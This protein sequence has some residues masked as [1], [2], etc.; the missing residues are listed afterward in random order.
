MK[1]KILSVL[2]IVAMVFGLCMPIYAATTM[3][4]T[5]ATYPTTLKQ[6]DPFVAKGVIT[7]DYYIRKVVIGVYNSSGAAEFDYTGLPGEKSYD[8]NNVDYLLYFSKLK[9]GS[10]TYKIVASDDNS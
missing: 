4:L 2:L 6:G 5:G 3:K 10:Y 7:S 1:K 9:N 8:I